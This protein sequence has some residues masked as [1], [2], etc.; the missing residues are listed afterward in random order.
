MKP[1]TRPHSSIVEQFFFG[2]VEGSSTPGKPYWNGLFKKLS[3]S[4]ITG[5]VDSGLNTNNSEGE[6]RS[7]APQGV[8]AL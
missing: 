2:L 3:L 4:E 8:S 1:R 6:S 5:G 7:I